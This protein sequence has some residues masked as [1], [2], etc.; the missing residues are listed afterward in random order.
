M[1]LEWR[2]IK[3]A[4]IFPTI[5][6]VGLSILGIFTLYEKPSRIPKGRAEEQIGQKRVPGACADSTESGGEIYPW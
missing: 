3:I 2:P 5:Y 6:F 1:S 4:M